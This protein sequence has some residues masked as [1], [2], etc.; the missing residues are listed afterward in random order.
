MT[1]QETVKLIVSHPAVRESISRAMQAAARTK[2]D[3]LWEMLS[4]EGKA[5]LL[6]TCP[7]AQGPVPALADA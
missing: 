1:Q 3:W 5:K 6:T 7:I 2:P 4:V